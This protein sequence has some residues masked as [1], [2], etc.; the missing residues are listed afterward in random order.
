MPLEMLVDDMPVLQG[1]TTLG[2]RQ[3]W[4]GLL[5]V[6]RKEPGWCCLG[7]LHADYSNCRAYFLQNTGFKVLVEPVVDRR[8]GTW[9]LAVASSVQLANA[10]SMT[11]RVY[12]GRLK[13]NWGGLAVSCFSGRVTGES[14]ASST[15][16]EFID[17]LPGCRRSV[18]LSWFG[19]GTM[20]ALAALLHT[21]DATN[22]LGAHT[23]GTLEPEIPP[24]AFPAL[25]KLINKTGCMYIY[26]QQKL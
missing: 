19:S 1:G 15:D 25:Y 10:C 24:V 13:R 17:I 18:P 16:S 21:E 22:G 9:S 5:Q 26:A 2:P 23:D 14:R 3:G 6:L 4:E 12:A 11:L 20:P 8:S 7:R